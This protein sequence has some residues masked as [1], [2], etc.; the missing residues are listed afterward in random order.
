MQ[1]E[2]IRVIRPYLFDSITAHPPITMSR[3]RAPGNL[4][5]L[6]HMGWCLLR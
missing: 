5:T 3:S 1:Y 4:H 2:S 6:A